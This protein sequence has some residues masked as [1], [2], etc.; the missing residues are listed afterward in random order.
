MAGTRFNIGV[1]PADG[2]LRQGADK[3]ALTWMDAKMGDWVVTPRRGKP[4][5]INALWYNALRLL[6]DW[7]DAAGDSRAPTELRA[8]AAQSAANRSTGDSGIE[9]GQH[10]YD[11]VDGEAWR[12]PGVPAESDLRRSRSS[13]RCSIPRAGQAVLHVVETRLLTPVGLRSLDPRH[14]DYQARHTTA[15]CARATAPTTR[16]RSG[17]G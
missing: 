13:I 10:L 2:L 6:A 14:P 12:R 11:V 7:H 15:I 17:P 16:E 3:L 5:E 1:D 9:D 4:V 8:L